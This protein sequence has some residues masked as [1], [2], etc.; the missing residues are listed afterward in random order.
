M[1]HSYKQ[2]HRLN[3]KELIEKSRSG[4]R[5]AQKLLFDQFNIPMMGVCLRYLKNRE[6]AEEVLIEGFYKVF[7]SLNSFKYENEIAFFTWMKKIMINQSLMLL[8]KKKEIR[9]LAIN[10]EIDKEVEDSPLDQ[11]SAHDIMH[12]IQ[13]IP[14]GYRTVFNLYEIEGYKHHEISSMLDI[15]IGT[16]KSQLFKAKKLLKDILKSKR[17]GYG[18]E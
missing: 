14:V 5:K 16:S 18:T 9:V 1:S 15:S 4:N 2:M 17:L 8:R 10:E 6:D 11:L 12:V 7:K 13:Q 3:T